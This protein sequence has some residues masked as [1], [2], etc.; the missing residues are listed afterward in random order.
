M[1]ILDINEFLER[2][3]NDKGLLCELLDI[4]VEDF[5]QK[6]TQLHEALRNNDATQVRKLA[7]ALKG[8]SAN[9][10]AHQLSGVLLELERMGKNN[11]LAGA[12]KLLAD[13]DKKF[14]VL[15]VRISR[16]REELK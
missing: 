12:D 14:E 5:Q 15:L 16:L 1:E 6:K 11:T 7:H 4:F 10:S 13:M 8:S 3:Q 9:I 2:I